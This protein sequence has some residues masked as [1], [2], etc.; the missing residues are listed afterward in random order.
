MPAYALRRL[1]HP[2]LRV[3]SYDLLLLLAF[4]V[5]ATLIGIAAGGNRQ[6]AALTLALGH[7]G[8]L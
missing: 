6:V 3:S 5:I 4:P 8:F 2:P 1:D 7:I